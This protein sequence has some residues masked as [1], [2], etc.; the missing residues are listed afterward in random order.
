MIAE[1]TLKALEFEKIV[2]L[3]SGNC[4]TPF[5]HEE[6][7][8]ICPM[9]DRD[10]I[11]QRLKETSE[12]KDIINFG[13][14]FPLYRM[15]D[16]RE[17]IEQSRIEG[18]LLES[19]QILS[20]DELLRSSAE[21]SNYDRES[22]ENFPGI[23]CYL[24]QFQTFPELRKEIK[25]ALDPKGEIKDSASG[26]LRKIRIE[27]GDARRA[28][29]AKLQSIMAA[30]QKQPGWQDDVVTSRNGRFVIPV[31]SSQFNSDMGILHDRSQSGAT[32]FVEPSQT[33]EI[34]NRINLLLQQER[35]EINRILRALTAEIGRRAEPLLSNCR[36]VG[37]LDRLH[38]CARFSEKIS[39]NAPTIT[40]DP[41]FDLKTARHPLLIV[42]FGGTE[43]VVP[44]TVALNEDRLCLLITG[45][46]TGGKTIMLKTIGL[47]V[48][49]AQSGIHIA[50]SEFS[51]LGIF[52]Q[53]FAD[54]G[55]EQS[56]EL[57]LSTFASHVRNIID[58]LNAVSESTL[59]LFDEIGAGTDPKEG[60]A[61]AE[62]IVLHAIEAGARIAATTHYSQ[63]KTLATEYHQI[64]NASLEFDLDTLSPTYRLLMGIPGSSYAVEI[65]E[66]LGMPEKICKRAAGL[67]GT[68]E[69]SLNGLIGAL[70]KELSGVRTDRADL[71][72]RLTK[73][74]Q[75]ESFYRTESEHLAREIASEKKKSLAETESFLEETRREVE[76]LVARIRSSKASDQSVKEFHRTLK[77]G[78]ESTRERSVQSAQSNVAGNVYEPGDTV[79]IL[80]LNA[81]GEIESLMGNDRAKVRVGNVV[82]I[83]DLRNLRK[84]EPSKEAKKAKRI[85]TMSVEPAESP[86]IHLRG[87]T[88]EEAIEALEKYIDRAI[89]AGLKQVY[90]IHGKGTGTLRRT[91]STFLKNHPDVESLRLGDWN[92]GGSGVTIVHL[93]A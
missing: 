63:L 23:T 64:E 27:M 47:S 53:V 65:A 45:P 60:A 86:E 3:I 36:L 40:D 20:I 59:L 56:L 70:E 13:R 81:E 90:V 49:M 32:L 62:S 11:R 41:S 82:T 61:L 69:R 28:I 38:A 14:P 48:L 5:G 72:E 91:L 42:Q 67:V 52:D 29:I 25:A 6:V 34:N 80:S 19:Q 17:L 9:Y 10:L 55:D 12:L 85:P 24:E 83:V 18:V 78:L 79:A 22:R 39:G 75:L 51:S 87:M 46:N 15:E 43:K 2:S 84:L 16:C 31:P 26:K 37:I 8:A 58:G 1:H 66:R 35:I 21:I 74:E 30:R 54:I 33:V 4:L 7:E 88:V 93:K 68:V 89:L 76:R 50:A 44:T 57:S 71:T 92:E 73:A 77:E